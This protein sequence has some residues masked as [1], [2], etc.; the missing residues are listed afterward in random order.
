MCGCGCGWSSC[1]RSRWEFFS[2]RGVCGV[3]ASVVTSGQSDA[4][5]YVVRVFDL[6]AVSRAVRLA[7]GS[8][9]VGQRGAVRL[10][11]YWAGGHMVVVV[12][13]LGVL[14]VVVGIAS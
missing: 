5:L 9:V 2:P 10:G 13:S 6:C 4:V 3:R 14:L 7:M 11:T 12:A 1:D 8:M